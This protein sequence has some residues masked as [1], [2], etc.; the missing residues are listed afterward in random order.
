MKELNIK[1]VFSIISAICFL[2]FG[3]MNFMSFYSIINASYAIPTDLSSPSL[4]TWSSL[5][6]FDYK[7]NHI[8]IN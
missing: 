4:I 8:I 1:R 2:V 3:I 7:F 6:T 5:Y